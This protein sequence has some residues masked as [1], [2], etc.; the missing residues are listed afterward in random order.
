MKT[1]IS[2]ALF[3]FIWL[4]GMS[5]AASVKVTGG[6]IE[7]ATE[8][9]VQ[10]YRGIPFATPPV[11]TLRW[12]A[13]Q[14]VKPWDGVLKTDTFARACYQFSGAIPAINVPAIE[15]SEDCLYLNVWTPAKSAGDKLPVMV[16]IH[17]GGFFG[18]TSLYDLY[19]G[20][21][22]AKRGVVYVSITYRL[23]K[24]GFLAHPEL[25]AE[26][27]YHAS[28]NYGL[29]D[30]I[31]ALHWVKAN[32]AAFG[33]DPESVT[34]FGESAGGISVSM[35]AGSPL[36]KGLFQRAI[37]QSGGALGPPGENAVQQLAVAEQAGMAFMQQLGCSSL[38]ELR[39]LPPDKIFAASSE[40][41]PVMD[42][43][44]I[45]DDLYLLY[46]QGQY[47]DVPV[48]I[49]TNSD[50]GGL[51]SPPRTPQQYKDEIRKRFGEHADTILRLYPGDTAAQ[52]TKSGGDIM[53]DATFA[54]PTWAWARLQSRTGKS[55]V[56]LYNF[57]QPLPP[58]S[59]MAS[60]GA[61]HG[62][63][64]PFMFQHLDQRPFAWQPKDYQLSEMMVSYWTNFARTGD[65]NGKGLP[66]W[67]VFQ[68]GKPTVMHLR[69]TPH[70]VP[71]PHLELLQAMDDY[72]AWR[73]SQQ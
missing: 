65:P 41:W 48:L 62:A 71:V 33:G 61:S 2:L 37:S 43:Y 31:A 73:R 20:E 42:G 12:A 34:I 47:N 38:A 6:L 45:P 14:V 67:P 25:S 70:A 51:F 3:C 36:A 56:Y 27:P 35:L 50:E 1:T 66:Q 29:L 8:D 54:W 19:S 26:A 40:G 11:G 69:D 13:P 24:F 23:G 18:G 39:K 52:A 60:D 17:G 72:F 59:P 49:G 15:V 58:G 55:R 9:G 28:G 4:T 64:M 22:I 63:E 21:Q 32:I 57:D 5:W 46:E 10:V 7:G 44:V 16:W 68:D 30:Q 53:R